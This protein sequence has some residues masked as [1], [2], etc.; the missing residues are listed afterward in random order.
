V[1]NKRLVIALVVSAAINLVAI[2]TFGFYWGEELH[3][4]RG[5]P[6]MPPPVAGNRESQLNQLKDRFQLS[7]QQ[8]D[9]IRVL[10]KEMQA[11]M[12]PML[13]TL[14]A[15]QEELMSLLKGSSFDQVQVDRLS[16]EIISL[17]V[18]VETRIIKNLLRMRN[19]LTPE[20][21]IK[22]D[23]L[24]IALRPPSR[25]GSERFGRNPP[26]GPPLGGPLPSGPPPG[27]PG[28]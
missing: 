25:L 5:F 6:P 19:V 2:F 27:E 9:T 10:D 20:Q 13:D 23:E 17:R 3:H 1:S 7:A 11:T 21:R 16:Q 24:L 28:H 18:S 15:K 22:M 14:S 26:K 12:R 8:M 4:R